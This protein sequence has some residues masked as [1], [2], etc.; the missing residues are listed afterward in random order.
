[1]NIFLLLTIFWGMFFGISYTMHY[2]YNVLYISPKDWSYFDNYPFKCGKCMQ[3]WSLI[4]S[5]IMVGMIIGNAE[6]AIFGVM[7]SALYGYGLYKNEKERIE[8]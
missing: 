2:L 3:T 4:A 7:L 8:E 6:F 5:Y 1:M